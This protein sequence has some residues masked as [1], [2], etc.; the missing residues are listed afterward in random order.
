MKRFNSDLSRRQGHDETVSSML[1]GNLMDVTGDV[2][3]LGVLSD[4]EDFDE[5]ELAGTE[6]SSTRINFDE[7][8]FKT[9]TSEEVQ[10]ADKILFSIFGVNVISVFTKLILSGQLQ[11]TDF[12]S[13]SI[14]YKCQAI[15]RGN[16]GIRY[17]K[18]WGLFW[19][20]CR[21]IV[22][23]RGLLA[24]RDHFCIPSLSQLVKF[25]KQIIQLCGLEES[26]LGKSGLQLKS[27]HLW[28][29]SKSTE[30]QGKPLALSVSIDGKK[31]SVTK[32]G[33]EDMGG[34]ANFANK[35]SENE[36]F[37]SV[38]KRIMDL[39]KLNDRSSLFTLYDSL[40]CACQEIVTKL[41]ALK[42]LETL[43]TNRLQKNPNL[44]KYINVLR[45]QYETGQKLMEKLGS[46]QC[47][48]INLIADKRKASDLLPKDDGS[49]LKDQ[50][51]YTDLTN[52]SV[53]ADN[54]NTTLITQSV[55]ANAL[56]DVPW[57]LLNAKLGNFSSIAKNSETFRK[58]I[59]LCYLSSEQVFMACGLGVLRPVQDMK[60]I[61]LQA[62]SFPSTMPPPKMADPAIVRSFCASMAPM[63]FG[64][65][66]QIQET[67]LFIKNGICA[68]PDFLILSY[69]D[70]LEFNVKI[71]A[72]LPN[73]FELSGETVAQC[74]VDS[75]ICGSRKG[76]LVV[77]CSDKSMT[78]LKVP[79][80]TCLAEDLLSLCDS[81]I[82]SDRCL[83]KRTK[84]ICSKQEKIKLAL[85]SLKDSVEVLGSYPLYDQFLSQDFGDEKVPNQL[86]E[87]MNE[88]REF[89]SK[90]A[91]ELVAVNVSGEYKQIIDSPPLMQIWQSSEQ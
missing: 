7:D 56:L 79:A 50:E 61:Y 78:V 19:A 43:N 71:I 74:V 59:E 46:V 18:S 32:E 25:K 9:V 55:K 36:E 1:G 69:T 48:I 60:D 4:E 49:Y 2:E 37:D 57:P 3:S 77:Q 80:D 53:E 39:W 51:N 65:N 52:L 76:S 13:Q 17:E 24:F 10:H 41:A 28:V 35:A 40:S 67:G 54:N 20:A 87:L 45:S 91:R 8:F 38:L 81:Y 5:E 85:K 58:L 34:I 30:C 44:Q 89:L 14:A 22:K 64:K 68:L 27:T 83:S 47:S 90:Q 62:H 82:K 23:S 42:K 70:T 26:S 21:N 73:V 31:I 15:L 84:D 11:P 88:K 66:C 29:E 72:D 63:T 86:R 75:L 6:E 33:T 16:S 12:V